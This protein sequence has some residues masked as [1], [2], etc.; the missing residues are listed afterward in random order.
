MKRRVISILFVLILSIN[1]GGCFNYREINRITF[2][3]SVIFDVDEYNNVILYLDCMRPYRDAGESSDKGKRILFKGQGKTALEA[4]RDINISSSNRIDLS[5][6]RAY[7][8]TEK[9]V[10][11][12]IKSY[13]NLINNNQ[14]LSFK[15]YMFVFYGDIENLLKISNN[16][17]EY[18]GMYLDELI[19]RNEHNGRIIKSN[20][21][22]YMTDR[23]TGDNVS[24]MSALQVKNDE[25]QSKIQLNGGVVIKEN[26]IV[27]R[28]EEKDALTYNILMDNI[29]EGT[30]EVHNP[31][32]IDKLIT[33]DILEEDN[34]TGITIEGDEIV[35]EK[36]INIRAAI[37]EIQGKLIVNDDVI[38][39]IKANE[40]WKIKNYQEELFKNYKEKGIDIFGV[41][42][43]LQEK[44]P[45]V[46]L[47]NVLSRTKLKTE[48][49]LIIE[50]SNL[51]KGSM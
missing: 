8:F 49:N 25:T 2:A 30:L 10:R 4:I 19:N 9:V 36:D 38:N 47:D 44:H 6:I 27:D 17:E 51:V 13:I 35:L 20:V 22:D 1:L 26:H 48:V 12:G 31:E 3:T 43:L 28:L 16:D 15:P 39:Q 42:R 33:L 45:N 24:L 32:E 29:R 40:E 18:L 11:K 21:K 23:L 37:G 34:N 41:T 5:Q 50:G 46:N 7:I 14:Q